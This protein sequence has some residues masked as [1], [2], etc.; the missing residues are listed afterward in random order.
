[1]DSHF[2]DDPARLNERGEELYALIEE[3][4][5]ICRSI[6]G[7]GF[8]RTM[9]VLQRVVPLS[10]R[11][12]PTGTQVF[13]WVIPKEW[14]VRDAWVKDSSGRKVIDFQ[15]SNLHLV[16]YSVPIHER[17][18]LARLRPHLFT[19][20]EH[21]DWIP[22]RTAYYSRTWGF[23]LRHRDYLELTDGEYEVFID[24]DLVDGS[25]TYGELFLAGEEKS[26]ILISC[27]AC[28]PSLCNDNLSG[29][30]LAALVAR[31]ISSQP[32]R[33]SY[34]FLF[35]PGTIGAITWLA[36]NEEKVSYIQH[37]LVLAGLADPGPL[38]Y[39]KSR[40]GNCAID[41]AAS[42]VLTKAGQRQG[43]LDFDPY[44]YDERQFCSPG[45][46]LPV[47]RLSRTPYGTYS[48][49]HTSADDLSFVSAE[50]LGQSYYTV[51][52]ILSLLENN[53][54]YESTNPK[55]EP[56]LG[57]R[58]LYSSPGPDEQALLWV[59]NYSDGKH[60][61]L[62]IAERSGLGFTRTQEAAE[63]LLGAGLLR[64]ASREE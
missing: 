28:H 30:A 29:V 41:R 63:R 1:M 33:Y 58:G 52:E 31:Q 21:P 60:D 34:R 10:T 37:G 50:R 22:Y 51:L 45:F 3:L 20:P 13:D 27:H 5:P 14:N 49:Y 24:T 54:S 42:Y 9:Q 4:Y 32:H 44:G 48:E 8:R 38:T 53:R 59:L 36:L 43:L 62:D 16:S 39:K 35:I 18:P 55:C 23:C 12:A 6:T 46:D 40:R 47:G 2:G 15:E 19:L 26:E 57:K 61:L 7:H 17:M 56:Q 25:L 11:E 64:L